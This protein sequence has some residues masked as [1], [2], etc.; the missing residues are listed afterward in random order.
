MDTMAIITDSK[1]DFLVDTTTGEV[2]HTRTSQEAL[3]DP[4]WD[5]AEIDPMVLGTWLISLSKGAARVLLAIVDHVARGNAIATDITDKAKKVCTTPAQAY[6]ALGEL[7][8][9]GVLVGE[10]ITARINP[11]I[12]Y[13]APYGLKSWM[14]GY[15][16]QH[17]YSH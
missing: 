15:E 10:G 2:L 1:Q 16:V 14:R 6:K 12:A 13:T 17:W 11:T 3:T 8:E 4:S 9:N 5:K 7:R